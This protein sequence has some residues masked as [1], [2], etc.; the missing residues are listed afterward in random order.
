MASFL[1]LVI[2]SPVI[3]VVA[4][5]IK[6]KTSGPVFFCQV[7][8]GRYGRPFIL[9]KFRTM[10]VNHGGD[11]ISLKGERRITPLGAILRKHKIDELPELWNVLR[12]DMSF[13]GP[14]PDVSEFT[15]RLEGEELRILQIRPGIT[16][17]ASLK[18]ADEEELVAAAPDPK[19]HYEE[20]IWPDKVRINV[21]YCDNRSFFGDILII[22]E[23]I[24]R[25]K[26]LKQESE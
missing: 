12:G 6:I 13:V 7:R 14:R 24:F 1:G 8:I 25:R 9:Y 26:G 17:P 2:V 19:K 11:S 20:V 15:G 16:S 5:L 4:M 21:E 22:L 10:I 18:Y 3:L 23:T